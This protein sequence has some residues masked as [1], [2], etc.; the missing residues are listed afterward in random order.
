[1]SLG[2]PCR[3]SWSESDGF[4]WKAPKCPVLILSKSDAEILE[5]FC[6][7]VSGAMVIVDL[8]DAGF[9]NAVSGAGEFTITLCGLAC[10]FGRLVRPENSLKDLHDV[11]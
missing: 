7:T 8:K 1:V 4:G 10:W 9:R 11:S 3:E 6:V 2:G 5:R